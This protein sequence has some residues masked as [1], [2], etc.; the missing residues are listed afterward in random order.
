VSQSSGVQ[1]DGT[2]T[3]GVT[4]LRRIDDNTLGWRSTDRTVGGVRLPDLQE[5]ILKRDVAKP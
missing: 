5:V 3:T 2:K 4:S 1:G